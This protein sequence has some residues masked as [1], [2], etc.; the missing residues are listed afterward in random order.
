M[1]ALPYGPHT[2][3]VRRFLQRFA[4]LDD[5]QWLTAAAAF[6]ALEGTRTFTAA[7]TALATAVERAGLAAARDAV[8]GPLLQIVRG[9]DGGEEHPVAAAAL[10]A[11][12]ALV[13]ADS[14]AERDFDTLY[15]PFAALVPVEGLGPA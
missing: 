6:E 11:A 13:A 8:V 14:I 2:R 5:A 3:I 10:G 9:A 7:E 15:G 4:A 12:L 1:D